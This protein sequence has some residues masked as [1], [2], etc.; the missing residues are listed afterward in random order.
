MKSK[1]YSLI[2][3][4]G[5]L[6]LPPVVVAS[7]MVSRTNI[8]LSLPVEKLVDDA[9]MS[10][11]PYQNKLPGEFID[12]DL[13]DELKKSTPV[14]LAELKQSSHSEVKISNV[15]SKRLLSIQV[16][17]FKSKKNAYRLEKKLHS[18]HLR[19]FVEALNNQN[20][21]IL[22]HVRFGKYTS[23][24][25]AEKALMNYKNSFDSRAFIVVR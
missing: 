18:Q 3:L 25:Q 9:Q 15:A 6:L 19:V 24:D 13:P 1:Q 12:V 16:A 22:Y 5:F 10:G 17:V 2:T 11:V 23:R 14:Y 21:E 20:N 8:H 7:D 4:T